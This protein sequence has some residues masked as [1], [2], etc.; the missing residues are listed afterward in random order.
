MY[1]CNLHCIYIFMQ[2]IFVCM[3]MCLCLYMHIGVSTVILGKPL[4]ALVKD[5]DPF[6]LQFKEAALRLIHSVTAVLY[7]PPWYKII[8]TKCHKEFDS[9]LREVYQLG[10]V[11]LSQRIE[12]LQKTT[13]E[14]RVADVGFLGQWL[15]DGKL[16]PQDIVRI[17]SD[18]LA[19][20]VDTVS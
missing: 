5:P 18:F 17:V 14:D 4:G 10:E 12:E 8:P 13:K 20:G 3:C 1:I 11:I 2:C 16:D 19:A 6:V 7:S 9:A 15:A